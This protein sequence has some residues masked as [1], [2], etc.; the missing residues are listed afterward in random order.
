MKII[1]QT[2]QDQ[3]KRQQL[4]LKQLGF[5]RGAVDG[6]WGPATIA[7]KK[8]MERSGFAPGIPNGGLPFSVSAKLPKGLSFGS[9]GL[10]NLLGF[11]P[12]KEVEKPVQ[13][14]TKQQGKQKQYDAPKEPDAESTPAEDSN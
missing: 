2:S 4:I 6:I 12:N 5:Y 1:D 3:L 13:V 8:A 14:T 9:D 11:D 10:L 7:A